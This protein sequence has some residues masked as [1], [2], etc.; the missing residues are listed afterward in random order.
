MR[1][2]ATDIHYRQLNEQIRVALTNGADSVE[3][4]HV[5]GQRYIGAGLGGQGRITVNGTPGNDLGAFMDGAELVVRGNAQDGVGNTMGSGRIVIHGDAGD[6]VG[7]S[8]RGGRVLVR[9]SVGYRAGIHMK[10][11]RGRFPVL[12]IGGSAGDYLGEYMAGGV[13]VVLGLDDGDRSQVGEWVGTG[14]HGGAIYVRG[15]LEQHQTG[16]EVGIGPVEDA[17]AQM[18]AGIIEDFRETFGLG[19]F[20]FRPGEFR[21]LFPQSARPYGNLYAY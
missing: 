14:M 19:E 9:G 2:D 11:Y 1:I 4:D 13:L 12:V 20:A 16:A 17:D 10:A 15:P 8:M 6:I 5:L 18:L 21:R 3:L 7:Y